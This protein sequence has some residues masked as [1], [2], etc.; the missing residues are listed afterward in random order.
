M[1]DRHVTC[2]LKRIVSGLAYHHYGFR[3]KET[4]YISLKFPPSYMMVQPVIQDIL[5]DCKYSH[6]GHN[7]E[8]AYRHGLANDARF[9][10]FWDFLFYNKFHFSAITNPLVP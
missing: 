2:A 7:H 1:E 4:G 8:F 5:K 9:G 6:I 10:T 3:V